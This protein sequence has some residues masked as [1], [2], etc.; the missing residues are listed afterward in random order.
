METIANIDYLTPQLSPAKAVKQPKKPFLMKLIRFGFNT[1]GRLFPKWAGQ[2]AFRLFT[3]PRY[4]ARHKVSDSIMEKARIFEFL[5]GGQMLKGYEWGSGGKTI[6]LVHGW[7][8]RGTALRN[9]VP[10]LL[11]KGYKVVAF[12]GPAHG[13]SSGSRTNLPH[14]AGAVNAAINHLG[15]VY[16][17]IT[18]SFGGSSTIYSL[19]NL[20]RAISLEKLVL[21]GVPADIEQ[22]FIRFLNQIAAP[23]GVQRQFEAIVTGMIKAPIESIDL[24]KVY[25][26]TRIG[27]TLVVH[28]KKDKVV[29]FSEAENLLENWENTSLLVSE[30]YGHYQI[31]KNK[32]LAAEIVKFMDG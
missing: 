5:Y 18:H 4:R 9:F 31:L 26:K 22:V 2:L 28:D 27:A 32:E 19:S 14:F 1:L 23:P 21:I 6:L 7:E 10:L 11:K 17:I 13:N 25:P 30:G 3:T 29:S 24:S 16:G 15:G 8:S 12:D 20:D